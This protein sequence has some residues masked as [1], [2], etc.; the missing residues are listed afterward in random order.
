[1]TTRSLI[2]LFV[3]IAF[4]FALIQVI[5]LE[6]YV[7]R[8]SEMSHESIDLIVIEDNQGLKNMFDHNV[9]A[10]MQE[11]IMEGV[12]RYAN[13]THGLV[14]EPSQN[15]LNDRSMQAR[16]EVCLIDEAIDPVAFQVFRLIREGAIKSKVR[17]EERKKK[18]VDDESDDLPKKLCML[19]THT[20]AHSRIQAIVNTWGSQCD[21][22]FA[23]S[24]ETDLSIG[25]IDLMHSWR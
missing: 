21:G 13:G 5:F 6:I 11:E 25:A 8:R 10:K 23:A 22:F 16:E 2:S 14:I 7:Y 17:M 4:F 24:N 18:E 3:S 20:G 1:M 15:L 9:F 12:A 19:Y